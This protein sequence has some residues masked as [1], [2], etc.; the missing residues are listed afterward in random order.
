M[1]WRE[2]NI[3]FKIQMSIDFFEK[4]NFSAFHF[5]SC[6]VFLICRKFHWVMLC[7]LFDSWSCSCA[8]EENCLGI[9][10]KVHIYYYLTC[11]IVI[12]DICV[13]EAIYLSKNLGCVECVFKY[14]SVTRN[15]EFFQ[16]INIQIFLIWWHFV[17]LKILP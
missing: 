1:I 14:L 10:Q 4:G 6:F 5:P 12:A 17:V 15:S 2:K 3:W 8:H 16:K 9:V 11:S 7:G 13:T